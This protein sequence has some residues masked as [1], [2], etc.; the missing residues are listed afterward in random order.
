MKFFKTYDP[1]SSFVTADGTRY[2]A[3]PLGIFEVTDSAHCAEIVTAFPDIT[4]EETQRRK[5][6]KAQEEAAQKVNAEF[7][8]KLEAVKAGK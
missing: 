5:V 6:I 1:S 8:A 2:V 3:T 4:E 7:A